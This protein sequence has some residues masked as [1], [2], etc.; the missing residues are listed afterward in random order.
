MKKGA[1]LVVKGII[2]PKE[3]DELF[4]ALDNLFDI[5]K[6]NVSH[7]TSEDIKNRILNKVRGVE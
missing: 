6:E 3:D 4:N 1:Y 5:P 2:K 7:E